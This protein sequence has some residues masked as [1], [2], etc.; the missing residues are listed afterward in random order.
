MSKDTKLCKLSFTNRPT[1][2]HFRIHIGLV[3]EFI[4]QHIAKLNLQQLMFSF[5]LRCEIE[6]MSTVFL[7]AQSRHVCVIYFL[8]PFQPY[9]VILIKSFSA[10]QYSSDRSFNQKKNRYLTS[11]EREAKQLSSKGMFHHFYWQLFVFCIL[12][13]Y[14][15]H[16]G[17]YRFCD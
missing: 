1:Q 6:F 11:L 13:S 2:T 15:P 14:S 7:Y 4:V 3:I 9:F 17:L 10:L 8:L 16:S 5:F 12:W